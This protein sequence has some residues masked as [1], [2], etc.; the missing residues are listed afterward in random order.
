[1][2]KIKQSHAGRR[3]EN[4]TPLFIPCAGLTSGSCVA[5]DVILLLIDWS[6]SLCSRMLLEG[7]VPSIPHFPQTGQGFQSLDMD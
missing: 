3:I 6:A 7:Q 2:Q 1:M 5:Q 4:N